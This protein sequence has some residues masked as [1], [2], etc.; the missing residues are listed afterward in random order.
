MLDAILFAAVVVDADALD[1]LVCARSEDHTVRTHDSAFVPRRVGLAWDVLAVVG[2]GLTIVGVAEVRVR[3]AVLVHLRLLRSVPK[4]K[5]VSV[6][7]VLLRVRGG[8]FVAQCVGSQTDSQP[9]RWHS[10]HSSF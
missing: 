3:D 2:G 9:M 5:R 1:K 7:Q 4:K 6:V 8:V 10:A